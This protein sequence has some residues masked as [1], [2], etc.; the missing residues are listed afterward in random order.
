MRKFLALFL[1]AGAATPAIAAAQDSETAHDRREA[2]AE[3]A[4]RERPERPAR[5]E[6]AAPIAVDRSAAQ[7]ETTEARQPRSRSGRGDLS[8]R[9]S[10]QDG[11]A[12]VQ[13]PAPARRVREAGDTVR[14]W[15]TRDRQ[16]PDSPSAVQERNLRGPEL[17]A[18]DGLAE[19]AQPVPGVLDRN[20][21]RT[22][23]DGGFANS[24]ESDRRPGRTVS[25][26]PRPGTEPPP[27]PTATATV[28]EPT[29]HW[30]GNWRNDR[31]Y[32]WYNYR[33]R[34]PS[35]FRIGFYF[36]PFGWNYHR[37]GIGW[38]L[39]PSYYS[40]R[41]WLDDPWMYRLPPAYGPYRWVRYWDDALLVNIYTGQVVDVI[42]NFF[43]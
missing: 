8:E 14:E 4:E 33:H 32:N 31:R 7:S 41:Y 18:A 5:A 25:R 26:T 17:P 1:L 22:R 2:R 38:R 30:S 3:R 6:R 28:A 29:R 36:D 42:H 10:W 9:S 23:P 16:R 20:R 43:W 15:R 34:N 37:Y 21:P 24:P 39:W 13:A 35:R 27:P 40:S 19:Q 11:S 12:E